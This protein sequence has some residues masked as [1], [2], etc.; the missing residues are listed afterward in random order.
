MDIALK[1]L[2]LMHRL[3]LIWDEAALQR[4]AKVIEKEVPEVEG[5]FTD[6]EVA[7]LERRRARYLS[8]ESKPHS[9]EESMRLAREGFKR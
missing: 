5:D 8:G 1:K 4:V 2:D 3:M 9:V 6:E 7:E